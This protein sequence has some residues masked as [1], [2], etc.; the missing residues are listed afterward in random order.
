MMTLQ[1]LRQDLFQLVGVKSSSAR[2]DIITAVNT[3]IRRSSE[4]FVNS[5]NWGFLDQC[6]DRVDI[7]LSAPYTTG[8]VTVTLDSKT[9]TGS[10][11]TWTKDMEGSFFYIGNNEYYEIRSFVSATSLTLAIPYQNTNA[12]A[13]T[14]SINK[15]FYN[16]PL[17]LVRPIASVAK[18]QMIG[19]G[20]D[21]VNFNP[22]AS[23]FD[24]V[25]S[26]GKPAWF[27]IT[28]NTKRAEYF[29]TGT[30]TIATSGGTSTWTI[31]SGTL[32][33]DIVDREVRI[34]G[35]TR[36]YF[37]A[38][39]G[40]STTFTTYDTYFNPADATSV[41]SAAS[42]AIT[43]KETKLI[44]F[45]SIPDTRYIF[46]M[47]YY[48]SLPDLISDSDISPIVL[49]GYEDAFLTQCRAKL[50]Q[51]GRTAMR[52]EQ[53]QSLTAAALAAYNEAWSSEQR[54]ETMKWQ[55][56]SRRPDRFQT[57]PSWIGQ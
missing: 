50:A 22:D 47:P 26:T 5:N 36:S 54:G 29:N 41:I 23:F 52:M 18:I 30:V 9:V 1:N 15:R 14:Y 8:T 11:T 34:V 6:T 32:P 7:P 39:R 17:N 20:W 49:A 46:S 31:S 4:H 44:G 35:E 3:A 43:P 45:S 19:G 21:V 55:G 33:T 56:A 10:G 42:Y 40:S 37:I 24:T 38:T 2:T 25:L 28:G 13:Q 57:G 16:L 48:R 51:D 27:G 53:V 12:S